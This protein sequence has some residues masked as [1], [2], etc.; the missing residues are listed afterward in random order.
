MW[1][2]KASCV[3]RTS[4]SSGVLLGAALA[5]LLV[6]KFCMSRKLSKNTSMDETTNE[7]NSLASLAILEQTICPVAMLTCWHASVSL[8]PAKY[9]SHTFMS[10][11]DHQTSALCQDSSFET[12]VASFESTAC[13]KRHAHSVLY[14]TVL[15]RLSGDNGIF[16]LPRHTCP[17]PAM[18]ALS[19]IP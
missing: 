13:L 18:S 11:N 8:F 16:S 17:M 9:Q 3:H 10:Q 19:D 1:S 6:Y 14:C 7:P 12:S 4:E 5:I 15:Y 2:S